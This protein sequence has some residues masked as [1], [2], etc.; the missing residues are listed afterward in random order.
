MPVPLKMAGFSC[1]YALQ[2]Q[3]RW[4]KLHKSQHYQI[5]ACIIEYIAIYETVFY[6]MTP[7]NGNIFRVSGTLCGE[8]TGHQWT[9]H[10]KASD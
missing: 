7:S 8:F 2:K 6:R 4:V 10:M 1:E 3:F 5:P 9:P